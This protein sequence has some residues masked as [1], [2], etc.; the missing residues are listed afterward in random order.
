MKKKWGISE[1]IV[2]PRIN[3]RVQELI[4]MAKPKNPS[5]KEQQV[6]EY[7]LAQKKIIRESTRNIKEARKLLKATKKLEILS[8]KTGVNF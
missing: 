6:R 3:K 4:E 7:L 8:R 5:S 1:N 2:I